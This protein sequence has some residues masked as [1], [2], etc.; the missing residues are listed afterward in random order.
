MSSTPSSADQSWEILYDQAS[1]LPGFVTDFVKS[2]ALPNRGIGLVA[3]RQPPADAPL[4]TV[5]A[6][7][8]IS[9]ETIA[10]YAQEHMEECAAFVQAI[11]TLPIELPIHPRLMVTLFLLS[12][13]HLE[14]PQGTSRPR[15]EF[16]R[17]FY[18]ALPKKIP[19][20][21]TWTETEREIIQGTSIA[22]ATQPR[23]F[24]NKFIHGALR[25]SE[26]APSW[27]KNLS[28]E[29]YV[30]ADTWY[31][32]RCLDGSIMVPIL[33]FANHSSKANARWERNE[34][35]DMMLVLRDD[36]AE[37][38][39]EG[40]EITISYGEEKGSGE[41]LFTYGFLEEELPYSKQMTALAIP[42]GD[43][44]AYELEAKMEVWKARAV[45]PPRLTLTVNTDGEH[46]EWDCP[47]FYLYILE[48]DDNIDFMSGYGSHEPG[49]TTLRAYIDDEFINEPADIVRILKARRNKWPVYQSR[50]NRAVLQ[51]VE[52]QLQVL[53][54]TDELA[55]NVAGREEVCR[56]GLKLR[57]QE[58]QLLEK[59]KEQL[60][61]EV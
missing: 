31:T 42:D 26:F 22:N 48:D 57:E 52:K 27:V 58:M 36:L 33:D 56:L 14:I 59:V 9:H 43:D 37:V 55:N 20:P 50:A 2:A 10:E 30:L 17:A 40:D 11:E 28:L 23:Q 53:R 18:D 21:S 13:P 12:I 44:V 49:L 35:G 45:G 19:L 47:W 41:L 38:V 54:E 25:A 15:G 32:S 3:T 1:K 16:Y 46:V 24:R 6:D 29:Q 8:V 60:S 7:Y 51:C 61:Q 4:L 39:K 34:A 5:P